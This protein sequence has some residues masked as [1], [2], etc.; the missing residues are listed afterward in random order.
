[1]RN[2]VRRGLGWG[3][4]AVTLL[5]LPGTASIAC[6]C[7]RDVVAEGL[8][9]PGKKNCPR[10]QITSTTVMS[11]TCQTSQATKV[12]SVSQ[13]SQT[14]QVSRGSCCKS[15]VTDA[16]SAVTPAQVQLHETRT[17][18]AAAA[19]TP[20][21]RS[22]ST[23]GTRAPPSPGTRDSAAPPASYLSDYLRL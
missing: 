10:C 9:A 15:K 18:P 16:R 17:T 11:R 20:A 22:T 5:S 1:M 14:S 2:G 13:T 7:P 12:S 3:V 23:G 4:L 8:N 6:A 21:L 19:P